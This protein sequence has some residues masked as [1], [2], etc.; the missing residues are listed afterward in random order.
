MASMI[1][2]SKLA[3]RESKWLLGILDWTEEKWSYSA[4]DRI[5]RWKWHFW[6]DPPPPTACRWVHRFWLLGICIEYCKLLSLSS[7][8]SV[9]MMVRAN[10]IMHYSGFHEGCY[11]IQKM[12]ADAYSRAQKNMKVSSMEF[13]QASRSKESVAGSWSELQWPGSSAWRPIRDFHSSSPPPRFA[14]RPQHMNK[15]YGLMASHHGPYNRVS[16]RVIKY[17]IVYCTTSFRL[18]GCLIMLIA[19]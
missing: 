19:Y 17:P 2:E 11:S 1:T 4:A 16:P 3:A 15:Y 6:K 9:F 12:V 7:S 18:V 13:R 14:N 10:L 5:M 8:S